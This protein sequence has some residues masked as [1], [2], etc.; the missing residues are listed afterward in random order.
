MK[1][2]EFTVKELFIINCFIFLALGTGFYAGYYYGGLQEVN[3]T[4]TI[5]YPWDSSTSSGSIYPDN[6]SDFNFEVMRDLFTPMYNDTVTVEHA[7]YIYGIDV[8]WV[9]HTR[10]LNSW[11][12][13]DKESYK[14]AFPLFDKIYLIE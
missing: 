2:K 5:D 4:Y 11:F 3:F 1:L 10:V 14:V 8:F 6:I 12:F 7:E 9:N 13:D